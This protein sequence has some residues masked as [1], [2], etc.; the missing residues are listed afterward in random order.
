MKSVTFAGKN[1]SNGSRLPEVK[2]EG[3]TGINMACMLAGELPTR[4]GFDHPLRNQR[5]EKSLGQV[6]GT[7]AC[8]RFGFD[9]GLDLDLQYI[10]F[11]WAI[12]DG[13]D[14]G[15]TVTQGVRTVLRRLVAVPNPSGETARGRLPMQLGK[16]S[17]SPLYT[18]CVHNNTRER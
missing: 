16:E 17:G 3:Q 2:Y 6:A 4:T 8:G 12:L 1:H 15:K 5:F 18:T 9:P 13:A 10:H 7:V 11:R 14:A